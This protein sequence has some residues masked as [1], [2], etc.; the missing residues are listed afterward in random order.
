MIRLEKSWEQVRE[1]S[2]SKQGSWVLSSGQ[3]EANKHFCGI[4]TSALSLHTNLKT[5][6]PHPTNVSLPGITSPLFKD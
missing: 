2:I 5:Q 3:W 4:Q 1:L 6:Y